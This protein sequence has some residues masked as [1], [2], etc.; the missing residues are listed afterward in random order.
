MIRL[1]F[2]CVLLLL[3]NSLVNAQSDRLVIPL[4]HGA[5]LTLV[6]EP[7]D[8]RSAKV[9]YGRGI[10]S[11]I[12][13]RVPFGIDGDLPRAI[14][15]EASLK[16]EGRLYKL[17]IT[18]MFN[19]WFTSTGFAEGFSLRREGDEWLLTG[20]FSDGAGAYGAVWKISKST[21]VRTWIGLPDHTKLK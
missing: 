14:L 10:V 12:D 16:I 9:T 6:R 2:C 20:D 1:G 8:P 19:P 4:N 7:F 13:G 21:C 15:K 17:P 3:S 11:K 5:Q 18:D